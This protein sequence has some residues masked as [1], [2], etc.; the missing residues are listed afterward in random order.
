MASR[1]TILIQA[2]MTSERCPGKSLKTICGVPLVQA[3]HENIKRQ[4]PDVNVVFLIPDD[5]RDDELATFFEKKGI[6]YFRGSRSDVLARYASAI[7]KLSLDSGSDL[8]CRLT[9]DCL[10]FDG[11][12][13]KKMIE[14]IVKDGLNYISN[15]L[16]PSFP[17][18][19]DIEI[20]RALDL[21]DM[22]NNLR[23][24][25]EREHVTPFF[26]KEN[27]AFSIGNF[28]SYVDLTSLRLT[29]DYQ[30][31]FSKVELFLARNEI[32][33]FNLD[34]SDLSSLPYSDI[35]KSPENLNLRNR[36]FIESKFSREMKNFINY[37]YQGYRV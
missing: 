14:V 13:F 29:F 3:F 30:Q 10:F 31:D 17:D 4:L 2:R 19:Y 25:F 16:V 27:S 21:L 32:E 18:G 20:F 35:L 23:D 8:I 7:R 34:L 22:N 26:Y 11:N 5:S 24:D 28:R 37:D 33:Y 6:D 12:A 1:V 15:R 9:G 36:V